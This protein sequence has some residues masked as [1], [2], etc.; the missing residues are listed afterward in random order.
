MTS[1]KSFIFAFIG[2]VIWIL[3]AILGGVFYFNSVSNHNN[4]LEDP[5]P[6]PVV[7]CGVVSGL[8]FLTAMVSVI[9]Y[10]LS[11]SRK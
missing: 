1:N 11:V 5:S 9:A 10:I 8:G 6:V 7:L 3:S 2:V 4:F